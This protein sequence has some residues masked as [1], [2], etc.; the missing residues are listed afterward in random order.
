[1]RVLLDENLPRG[2]KQF[3]TGHEVTTVPEAGWSGAADGDLLRWAVERFDALV[4]ADRNLEFQQNFTMSSI[5][6]VVVS[7]HNTRIQTLRPL[8]PLIL[9]AVNSGRRGTVIR[10]P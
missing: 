8:V 2:L 9:D 10:V 5:L 1:M 4:T 6:V 3:L 7:V